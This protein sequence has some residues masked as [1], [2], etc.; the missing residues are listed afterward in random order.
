[1]QAPTRDPSDFCIAH[2]AEPVLFMPEKAKRTSTPKCFL[3]MGSFSVFEVRFIG[4]VVGVRV[5]FDF[6]VSLDGCATGVAQPNLAWL[7]LV[8]TRFTEEGPVT[9]TMRRKILAI[10]ESLAAAN[11]TDLAVQTELAD[12]YFRAAGVLQNTGD[13]AGALKTL[14]QAQPFMQRIAAGHSDPRLQDR[15]AGLYYFTGLALE[16]SG[17]FANALQNYRN[18]AS[19][20]EPIAIDPGANVFV[21]A[22]LVADYN[23]MAKM[24]TETGHV[25]EAIPVAAKALGIMK[26]LSEANPN[27]ATFREWLAEAYDISAD[28]QVQK[29]NLEPALDLDRRAQEIFTELHDADPSNQLAAGNLAFSDLSIGE[30]LVRQGKITHGLRNIQAAFVIVQGIGTPKTLWD[31]T[32]FS[33]TYSDLGMAYIALAEH[34]VPLAEKTRDWSEARSWSQKALDVWGEKAKLGTTDALGHNQA[35]AISQQLAKCDAN[36]QALKT[37]PNVQDH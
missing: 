28:V 5:T 31:S 10:R 34:A 21:R 4:R 24:L 36:L 9:T 3:H 8:I 30:V 37:Q 26:Q 15:I 33:Q 18:G 2:S 22:H 11:P 14:Q 32:V 25:D 16:K 35:A 23:G 6:N 13:F 1:V 27:N 12:E 20:R 7:P 19:V 17:D 29:G